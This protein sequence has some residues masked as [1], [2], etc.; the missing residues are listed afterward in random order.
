MTEPSS[1]PNAAPETS[2][3][4]PD[5]LGSIGPYRLMELLGKGGMGEVYRAEDTRLQRTVALKVM[6]E[7]F[8]KSP[9]SRK[10]ILEE[11]RSMAAVYHDN[12]ATLFEV[13][14]RD[15]TP[16]LAMELLQGSTLE[17]ALQ[18][19]RRFTSEEVVAIADQV[20]QGLEAAHER[21]IIHR[22]IKPANLWLQSPTER[23]KI[24]DFGLALAGSAVQGLAKGESVVGT[25]GYLS[26]EQARNDHVDERTDLY[27][28]GVV[29]YELCAGKVPLLANNTPTQL[30]N[31]LCKPP[32]PLSEQT[33][34]GEPV[35]VPAAL[36][37]LI[38]RLLAKDPGG[39]YESAT[40][41]RQRLSAIRSEMDAE[42]QSALAIQIDPVNSGVGAADSS[43]E[44]E[45]SAKPKPSRPRMAWVIALAACVLGIVVGL[46]WWALGTSQQ[47]TQSLASV[48]AIEAKPEAPAVLAS[49]LT[50]LKLTGN[51]IANPEVAVGEM[52]RFRLQLSNQAESSETDPRVRFSEAK[53]IARITTYLQQEGMPKRKAPAFPRSFSPRQLPGPGETQSIEVQFLASNLAQERFDVLF[54]LQSPAGAVVDSK[55]T[56]MDV[57]E[58]LRTGDLLG[59]QTVRTLAGQGADT[60]VQRGSGENFGKKPYVE[61]HRS[62]KEQGYALKIA[63]LRFD[64]TQLD[65]PS[66]AGGDSAKSVL[67]RIDRSAL[68]LSVAPDSLAS[69]F[70]VQ[71]HGWPDDVLGA[72]GM[73]PR[74]WQEASESDSL[75][76]Y[77]G[78][79][80]KDGFEQLVPLGEFDFDNAA[81]VLKDK[82]DAVRFVSKAMDEFLRTSSGVVTL[83]LSTKSWTNHPSR[84]HTQE[85]S[86]ELAPA[87]AVRWKTEPPAP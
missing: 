4:V 6:N 51:V 24:L 78:A 39:R 5:T 23:V 53:Q 47:A 64:L 76:K 49:E 62:G 31:I 71:V 40:A 68:L 2:G 17:E 59:F 48:P 42:K 43:G 32:L 37:Q 57:V 8:S 21:G 25:P 29:M 34:D 20:A 69:L 82:P 35:Q 45:Q 73:G 1:V 67:A 52:A 74:K 16:F 33:R 65:P 77:E 18:Q 11:A 46:G 87:M 83:V 3:D 44:A 60:F 55:R 84:F 36:E 58:N 79:P 56:Q 72:D 86:P 80:W 61:V 81:Q 7:R 38:M 41:L 13:G 12:V 10:R 28:L 14:Q 26:P 30:V 50:Q 85:R 22:D 54:E 19:E 15:G 27:S 70:N 63:V 66:G 9:N 75:L